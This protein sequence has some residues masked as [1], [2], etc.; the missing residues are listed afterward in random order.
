MPFY[1]QQRWGDHSHWRIKFYRRLDIAVY[2]NVE[3]SSGL[4]TIVGR[5]QVTDLRHVGRHS[6]IVL[7]TIATATE[8]IKRNECY[9]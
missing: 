1:F 3:E 6:C 9:A 4:T 5:A 2:G 7:L 8:I